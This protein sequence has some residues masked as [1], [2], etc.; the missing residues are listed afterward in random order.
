MRKV[1][2]LLIASLLILV[3]E[4][5]SE[6]EIQNKDD[7]ASTPEWVDTDEKSTFFEVIEVNGVK[8]LRYIPFE[9]RKM[10]SQEH[11]MRHDMQQP[12]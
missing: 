9:E 12:K 5:Y 8:R 4:S 10:K 11:I 6:D 1:L 2:G 3:A 7:K